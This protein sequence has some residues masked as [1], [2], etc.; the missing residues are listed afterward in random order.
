MMRKFGENW[1]EN[2]F[3]LAYLITFRTYGNWLHG[4]KRYSVDVH[5]DMNIYGASKVLPNDRLSDLMRRNMKNRSFALDMQQRALV[6]EAMNEVCQ[7]RQYRILA[8]NV[9]TNHIHVVVSAQEKPEKITDT[10]KQYATRKLRER[11]AI[12]LNTQPWSRGRSRRYLWKDENV[13][14]AINYVL[15]C[16]GDLTFEEFCETADEGKRDG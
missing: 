7:Y 8:L 16:Q 2:E 15:Y 9:R 1:D 5:R 4:D 14:A 11:K 12:D 13:D 10:F 6:S 3:P